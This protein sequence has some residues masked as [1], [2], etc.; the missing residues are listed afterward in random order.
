MLIVDSRW[1]GKHGIGRFSDE[2]IKRL[3]ISYNIL[4]SSKSPS[5]PLDIF[6]FHRLKASSKDVIYSPGYNAGFSRAK[7]ILTLHDLFHLTSKGETSLMRRIY[8]KYIIR[9]AIQRSKVVMTVS[10]TSAN[11]IRTWLNDSSIN[12]INVGNG[13]SEI[14]S[15][16]GERYQTKSDYFLYVG[17]LRPH[18]NVPILFEAISKRK[19]F[20]L[21]IVTKEKKEALKLAKKYGVIEQVEIFENVDDKKLATFYRGARGVLIPS[22]SEGFGYPAVEA[23]RCGKKVAF[24]KG[25]TQVSEIVRESGVKVESSNISDQWVDAMDKMLEPY[26]EEEIAKKSEIYNFDTVSQNINKVLETFL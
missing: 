4:G 19:D 22:I 3:D 12:V 2:I 8:Y 18:K 7:Q 1:T 24:W 5:S 10:D 26:E 11:E 20:R 23:M 13:C 21:V 9:L 17:N 15:H 25:C 16:L 14:F 6:N